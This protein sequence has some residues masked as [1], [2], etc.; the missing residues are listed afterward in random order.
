MRL[1]AVFDTNI[2]F[3]AVGWGGKPAQCVQLARDGEID[4]LTCGEILDELADKLGKKLLFSDE[5]ITE[6]LGSLL[7]FLEPVSISGRIT[8]ASPD[9]KDD[10]VLECASTG[11]ATHVV[12]G[13]RKHLLRLGQFEAIPIVSAAEFLGLHGAHQ[14]T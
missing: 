5:Q 14:Q 9:P 10:M 12:S 2:L 3:S 4:G 6:V 11:K 7:H 1:R 13:D 8:G